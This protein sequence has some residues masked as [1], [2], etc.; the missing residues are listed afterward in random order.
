MFFFGGFYLYSLTDDNG[1]AHRRTVVW[2]TTP[3]K[4]KSNGRSFQ[5]LEDSGVTSID[6]S[7]SMQIPK[8]RASLNEIEQ[9][10]GM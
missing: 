1:R 10:G 4:S 9:I 7:C 5:D 6:S 2:D 8:L 3:I